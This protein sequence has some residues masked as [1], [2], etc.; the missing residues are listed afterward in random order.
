MENNTENRTVNENR[1]E[2][3][4]EQTDRQ[5]EQSAPPEPVQNF[6]P[7]ERKC[8]V[9]YTESFKDYAVSRVMDSKLSV[10][11]VSREL[12]LDRS[13]LEGWL[14][15]RGLYERY[16]RDPSI[17]RKTGSNVYSEEFKEHAVSLVIDKKQSPRSVAQEIGCSYRVLCDW[18]QKE[19]K[20][21]REK[22][23]LDNSKPQERLSAE[24]I[25]LQEECQRLDEQLERLNA[26][27]RLLQADGEVY[28]G[29]VRV[30]KEKMREYQERTKTSPVKTSAVQAELDYK[31][32]FG[33]RL[34]CFRRGTGTTGTYMTRCELAAKIGVP[35]D[36][37]MSWECGVSAP[38]LYLL[39]AIAAAL[40]TTPGALLPEPEGQADRARESN[41]GIADDV[42]TEGDVLTGGNLR[43]CVAI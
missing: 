38:P 8:G 41:P 11:R 24:Y 39:P 27:D 2:Q 3:S 6:A 14:R 9:R 19:R 20:K 35:F 23:R 22:R 32:C 36:V 40:G 33:A 17:S 25:L 18:L 43:G 4:V 34:R 13:V 1:S 7:A 5:T 29:Q 16:L 26:R 31:V 15:Q 30:W 12:G 42:L 37:V 21:R 28:M 10:N